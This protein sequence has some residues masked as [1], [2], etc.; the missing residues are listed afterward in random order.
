ME[1][2]PS[3]KVYNT[4]FYAAGL[5]DGGWRSKDRGELIKEYSFIEEK[6]GIDEL[7]ATLE[8]IDAA[9]PKRI[10]IDG[11]GTFI[12]AIEAVNAVHWSVIVSYMA[13]GYYGLIR[14]QMPPC[15][16]DELLERYLKIAPYDLIMGSSPAK[17]LQLHKA[18][19]LAGRTLAGYFY[20]P[21]QD[22]DESER[23]RTI[24]WYDKLMEQAGN[25]TVC[26]V[27]GCTEENACGDGCYWVEPGLC[28]SCTSSLPTLSGDLELYQ[29]S[30]E[31]YGPYEQEYSGKRIKLFRKRM[32]LTQKELGN[33]CGIGEATIRKY[34]LGIRNPKLPALQKIAAAL[35]VTFIDLLP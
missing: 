26:R 1:T 30:F 11:G 33:I 6:M 28:S 3:K 29:N 22:D 4:W 5:Y 27:C 8:Q 20:L 31:P 34:E 13:T 14:V 7:C 21:G 32:E 23:V 12:S 24:R 18:L 19:L 25:E 10:S 2:K 35:N 15:S 9:P 16:L 17:N